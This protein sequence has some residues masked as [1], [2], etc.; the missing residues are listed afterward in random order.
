MEVNKIDPQTLTLLH[1]AFEIVLEQ[2]N[3]SF[4]KIGI[5]EEGEQLLFLYEGKDGKVHVFKWS[6]ASSF[7]VSIGVLAQSVLMPII[8]HLRLLS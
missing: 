1:K 2:N 7:G 8:P 6:K 3:V 4:H 5:T